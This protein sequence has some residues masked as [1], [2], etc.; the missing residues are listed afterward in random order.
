VKAAFKSED[1]AVAQVMCALAEGR[2]FR[3]NERRN[4]PGL[5]VRDGTVRLLLLQYAAH[6]RN[7]ANPAVAEFAS[8]TAEVLPDRHEQ[9]LRA[10]LAE[11][12]ARNPTHLFA[13]ALREQ[14]IPG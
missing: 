11:W 1:A 7:A 2:T 6:E 10:D 9:G 4:L 5:V 12:A 13:A 8:E 3:P 14:G